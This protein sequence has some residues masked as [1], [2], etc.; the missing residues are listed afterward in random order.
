MVDH[1]PDMTAT[2]PEGDEIAAPAS[3]WRRHCLRLL[4]AGCVAAATVTGAALPLLLVDS[5]FRGYVSQAQIEVSQTAYDAP[6][7]TRFLAMA[8]R[9]LLSPRGLDRISSDLKLKPADLVGVRKQGEFHLLVD[10]LTG[11]DAR[12]LSPREALN[13]AVGDGIGLEL[14]P[15]ETT[16]IVTS[17]AATPEAA[18]RLTDY[19]SMR[20]MADGKAGTMT[21]AVRE[22][23]RARTRMDEAEAAL[24]GFQ[25]RHG[26]AV[27]EVQQ[28][29]QQLRDV[30]ERIT[31]A[32]RQ[33]QSLQADLAAASALKPNDLFSKPLPSGIA[34]SAL[35]DIRQKHAAAS[36]ALS[37]ISVDYGPKH[38]RH[39]AA[40]NAEDAVQALAAPALRQLLDALRADEK[41]L[42]E[43]IAD[44]EAERKKNLDRL[45]GLGVA[46]GEFSRLQGELETARN[47]YLEASERRDL[48]SAATP[49]LETRLAKKAG[50]GELSRDL[51][52]AA[53][54]A[55]GGGLIGLLG[56][57][58]LLTYRRP[59]E[60]EQDASAFE[61]EAAIRL[62]EEEPAQFSEFE[63]IE[64]AVFDDLQ[65]PDAETAG[66]DAG[67]D[68][69]SFADYYC[70]A[71]NDDERMPLDERVRQVLMGNRTV[72]IAGQAPSALPPLLAD[73]LAGHADHAQAEA[74]ELMEL[75]REL[76]LLRERLVD[77]ADHQ[78]DYRKTA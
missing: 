41:R 78:E 5:G 44:A 61:P 46:P 27:T 29:E 77:Y 49:A 28:L 72:G 21:P 17:R 68:E 11:A 39:I 38:P 20:I 57:L 32:T 47:T 3:Q 16:L 63:P 8:R 53:M 42:A 73:A 15:D 60:E 45:N 58:Y 6:D 18:M 52:Q 1:S 19:L 34:F 22:M 75:R 30:N 13:S 76:A 54:M 51:A 71:V 26:D 35:E 50:P 24:S 33:Q 56:S 9:T 48:S 10:L 4:T 64:P 14:S 2:R 55:G 67:H 36:M 59:D 40:R 62:P 25:M 7:A 43:E 12:P 70:G 66:L 23:E 31:A 37:S 69:E 65:S 74:E